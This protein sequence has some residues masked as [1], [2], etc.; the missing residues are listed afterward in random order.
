M[1]NNVYF[2]LI[3]GR[4][5]GSE[6][7]GDGFISVE[8]ES[9]HVYLF[10]CAANIESAGRIAIEFLISDDFDVTGTTMMFLSMP[11]QPISTV[12]KV[13]CQWMLESRPSDDANEILP[14][15][16]GMGLQDWE[17]RKVFD[18]FVRYVMA[19][20]FQGVEL[21]FE[22]AKPELELIE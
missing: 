21:V 13:A 2:K 16:E 6:N 1:S 10:P 9:T 3:E 8:N 17:A 12:E 5:T 11:K 22:P 18:L 20:L 14:W 4:L 7:T 15:L 19:T